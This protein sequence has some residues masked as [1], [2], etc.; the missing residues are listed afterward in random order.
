MDIP[1]DDLTATF[2]DYADVVCASLEGCGE[3]A[4]VVG[5]SLGGVV[6]PLVAA[7]RPVRHLVYL[8][9]YAPEIGRSLAGQLAADPGMVN[10]VIYPGLQHDASARITWVDF[11]L[12]R[13]VMYGDCDEA[14]AEAAVERLRPQSTA[15]Y[16]VPCSLAEFPSV[17]CTYILCEEDRCLGVEWAR[18]IARE[19]L[20]ADLI[21][22][23]GS[24]SPFL[25][26]P[27]RLAD[28]LLELL[29]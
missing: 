11:A 12:A 25:S 14:T 18:R 20:G 22:L 10:P 5:H 1:I 13:A 19:R 17:S 29:E 9:G 26:Q 24:H 2:D 28:V 21:E 6:I 8:C 23:P 16:A 3:D 4:I 15:G 27:R 7:R